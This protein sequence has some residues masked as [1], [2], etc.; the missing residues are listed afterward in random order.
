[1]P[2]RSLYVAALFALALPVAA[3]E[4]LP[5]TKP[6]PVQGDLAAKM[7]EGFD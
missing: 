7:V 1:M 6:L 3:A 5:D 4:P 2:S